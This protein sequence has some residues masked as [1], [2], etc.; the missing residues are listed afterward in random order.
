MT[1]G[2]SDRTSP[3]VAPPGPA[4]RGL[5][6]RLAHARAHGAYDRFVDR[7]DDPMLVLALVFVG[8]LVWPLLDA[9]PSRPVRVLLR[10]ADV[11]I[12]IVFAAEYLVRLV[13]APDR[14]RFV[15]RHVPDLVVVVV[16]PLRGLRV[17]VA[18]LR[19]M[20]LV[21]V[22]GRLSRQSL[23]VRTGTYTA[24]LAV[25]VLFAGAVTVRAAER[26]A[27]EANITSFGDA[28]WWSL[29]TMTTVG[30]GDRFPVTTQ[31]RVLAA[32]VMLSGIAVLGV[33]TASIA[34]WFVGQFTAVATAVEDEVDE[35]REEVDQVGDAVREVSVDVD[36]MGRAVDEV[37]E[38]VGA[39]ERAGAG[40]RAELLAA[41]R[42]VAARL[43]G[44][45]RAVAALADDRSARRVD[46]GPDVLDDRSV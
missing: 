28:L 2:P 17:M 10:W 37:G 7:T 39:D 22:V 42:A 32:G 9:D 16:P 3:E 25:G 45:E 46:V 23:R 43:D 33:V 34:A 11:A 15:R 4:P 12:W 27:P 24:I 20:G 18:L 8:V 36:R 31:G 26:D 30:Y 1:A 38:L 14:W 41:V 29:T 6:A 40:E 13:L 21:S 5:R 44:L 19:L 35:V